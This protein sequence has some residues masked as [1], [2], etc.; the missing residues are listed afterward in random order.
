MASSFELNDRAWALADECAAKA[1]ELRL[2]VRTMPCGAR[3]LDAGVNT[4]GGLAAG[5][6]LARLCMGGLGHIT[7]TELAFGEQR[8]PGVQVWTDHPAIAC[9]ASQY[10]GWAINP[11]GFFA[12][13]SGPIRAHARVEQEL[14]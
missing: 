2:D 10:A 4:S 6:M 9:M 14:F 13:G 5:L 7:F 11:S 8:Y 3:I 1:V 12:M